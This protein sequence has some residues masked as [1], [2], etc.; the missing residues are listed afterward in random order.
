MGKSCT[1]PYL[2]CRERIVLHEEIPMA[3][4]CHL[5]CHSYSSWLYTHC[6]LASCWPL[7]CLWTHSLACHAYN[8]YWHTN[9]QS[10][11]KSTHIL[12][13]TPWK[14][15]EK[16]FLHSTFCKLPGLFM[17]LHVLALYTCNSR[18]SCSSCPSWMSV[19][20]NFSHTEDNLSL[21]LHTFIA[22]AACMTVSTADSPEI[23]IKGSVT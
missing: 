20:I 16:S 3:T 23:L 22:L 12:T 9:W 19:M 8:S 7:C 1:S 6:N 5:S 17:Q 2:W 15:A 11:G 14:L 18:H 10:R 13:F 21:V 4:W